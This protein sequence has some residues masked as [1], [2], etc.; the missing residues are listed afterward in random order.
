MI[1]AGLIDTHAHLGDRRFDQDRQDI[2]TQ[3]L[4]MG[5][6][7]IICVG[8]TVEDA[9]RNIE[10][11]ER[12]ATLHAAAGLFP[13][14]LE[15]NT[16][17]AMDALIRSRHPALVAIGE[18][19]LDYWIAKEAVQRERQRQVLL[20]F[21]N[22]SS[23]FDLPLNVHSRS[24]GRQT[25]DLLL[26]AGAQKVQMHAYDGRASFA[27]PAVE[28]GYYFSI[29]PSIVRSR[30]KQKLVR[31]LPLANLLLESDSP[32]LGPQAQVRNIPGNIR[33]AATAI[34]EIKGLAVKAVIERTG[35]N[36]CELY[37]RALCSEPTQKKI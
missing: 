19:G 31:H 16:V 18:V 33:I 24:A 4:T 17:V 25:L 22:L 1:T 32:V 29:P 8:E 14:Q 13:D 35:A 10:L 11:A 21:V 36:A 12:F 30:Q 15:D 23:A 3:S 5:V 7:A 27:L 28:A 2:I 34:A 9:H 37:G 20:R 26:R 6:R